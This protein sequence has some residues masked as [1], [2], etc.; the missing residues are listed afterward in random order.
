MANG[1]HAG[2]SGRR[3]RALGFRTYQDY[4][5]S[6]HW[7]K[8]KRLCRRKKK[9][10]ECVI[11]KGLE[12]G[13]MV[14][15]HVTY[16]RLGSESIDDVVLLCGRCHDLLHIVHKTHDIPL[17]D[18]P[19][20]ASYVIKAIREHGTETYGRDIRRRNK[21]LRKSRRA[22]KAEEAKKRAEKEIA[23]EKRIQREYEDRIARKYLR[24]MDHLVRPPSVNDKASIG[25]LPVDGMCG[26]V[27][28][29]IG[30][31]VRRKVKR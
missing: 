19:I 24:D 2:E 21:K 13:A 16:E 17:G 8:F 25:C 9:P 14:L 4:L 11:C 26:R 7:R 28:I 10:F 31:T 27:R 12:S 5:K 1:Y 3:A 23:R 29:S 6:D 30:L 20:A 18:F 15:H 22:I